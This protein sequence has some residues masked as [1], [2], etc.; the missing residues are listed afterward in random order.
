MKAIYGNFGTEE[1]YGAFS[2]PLS[3]TLM[4]RVN[5][6]RDRDGVIEQIGP[7]GVD[8]DGS[9]IAVRVKWLATDD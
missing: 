2:G 1:Y 7:K 3:D 5:P 6:L 9:N 8:R 4:G